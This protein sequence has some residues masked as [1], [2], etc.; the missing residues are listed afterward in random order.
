MIRADAP[1]AVARDFLAA[2]DAR[3][4]ADVAERCAEPALR[5]LRDAAARSIELGREHNGTSSDDAAPHEPLGVYGDDLPDMAAFR[6]LPLRE[7]FVR[8]LSRPDL[9]LQRAQ[10]RTIEEVEVRGEEAVCRYRVSSDETTELRL[11]QRDG[12]WLAIPNA[13]ILS[14]VILSQALWRRRLDP[15]DSDA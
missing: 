1:E 6:A 3:R 9:P 4:C 8:Y 12:K 15:A 13:D 7:F 5:E 14:A 2:F 11:V 10:R